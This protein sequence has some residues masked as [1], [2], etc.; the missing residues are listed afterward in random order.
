MTRFKEKHFSDESYKE[1][2]GAIK[3]DG[4]ASVRIDFLSDNTDSVC[5]DACLTN[6]KRY[7]LR[8]D[9]DMSADGAL[10]LGKIEHE[11]GI[12]SNFFFQL[13][14][15]TY[16]ML[17]ERCIAICKELQYMGHLVGLHV[18]SALFREDE[19]NILATINW[20]RESLFPIDYAVSFHRPAKDTLGKRYMAFVSA[21]ADNLFNT[22]L[23]ASDS[24][25]EDFFYEKL[26]AILDKKVPFF[27]LLLHP[28]W[29]ENETDK[30]AIRMRLKARYADFMDSYLASNFPKVFKKIIEEDGNRCSD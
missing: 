15:A 30:A 16:Q 7:I 21:Y 6:G 19:E 28:C 13:N 5:S 26:D 17:S 20:I 3:A 1:V 10:K 2:L 14:S 29:W 4:Y 8:H 9:V 27:Q 12:T 24:R 25:G 22:E 18:D 23:Y 11:M